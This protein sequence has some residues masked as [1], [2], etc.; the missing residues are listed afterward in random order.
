MVQDSVY[1]LLQYAYLS[2]ESLY[3]LS[4]FPEL[5]IH[6][7]SQRVNAGVYRTGPSPP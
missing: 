1:S 6:F 4:D 7:D 2:T 3:L 5:A